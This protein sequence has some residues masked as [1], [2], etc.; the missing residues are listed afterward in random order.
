MPRARYDGP[1]DVFKL[2]EEDKGTVR[3]AIGSFPQEVMDRYSSGDNKNTDTHY[4]TKES[5]LKAGEVEQAKVVA[6]SD[7][8]VPVE[9]RV[10]TGEKSGT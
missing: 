3:G 6:T 8:P 5:E 10:V 9:R 1:A 7:A 4:F 2:S